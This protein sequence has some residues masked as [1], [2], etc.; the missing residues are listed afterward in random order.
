MADV[1]VTR[2]DLDTFTG[3]DGTTGR[4]LLGVLVLRGRLDAGERFL[5]HRIQLG[6][7]FRGRAGGCF[8]DLLVDRVH[9]ST[10]LDP[11][12]LRDDLCAQRGRSGGI[13]GDLLEPA[14]LFEPLVGGG[15]GHHSGSLLAGLADGIRRWWRFATTV[16]SR[17][18][19]G[20]EPA[21]RLTTGR[22]LCHHG[23]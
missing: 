4:A 3:V 12:Q 1:T 21:R 9:R 10:G 8:A 5:C 20:A 23:P 13:V 11:L 22:A 15:A 19:L 14:D 6:A 18:M 2:P 17:L 7:S 16:V